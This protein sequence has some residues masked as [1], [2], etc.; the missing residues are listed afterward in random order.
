[1][2]STPKRTEDA[3]T[4]AELPIAFLLVLDSED[5]YQFAEFSLFEAIR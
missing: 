4:S 5:A 1:M 2:K 3:G